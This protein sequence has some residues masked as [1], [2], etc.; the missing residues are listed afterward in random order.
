ML[1]DA[2]LDLWW[3]KKTY[4]DRK[5]YTKN[6]KFFDDQI[7]F[8]VKHETPCGPFDMNWNNVYL[9]IAV[10]LTILFKKSIYAST[11]IKVEHEWN[12]Q[13]SW[14]VLRII[15]WYKYDELKTNPLSLF[16][17]LTLKVWRKG[18]QF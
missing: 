16:V 4:T 6:Q 15:F 7:I 14:T 11:I 18:K 8:Y 13:P 2:I 1:K 5:D 10:Y 9:M 17:F 3:I 12:G